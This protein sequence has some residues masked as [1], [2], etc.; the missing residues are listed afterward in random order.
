M[1]KNGR[2]MLKCKCVE[3]GITKTKF[4]KSQSGGALARYKGPSTTDKIAY[5]ASNFVTP[6]PSFGAMARLLAGQAFK[7]VKDNVDYYRKGK[8]I[9]IHK[10]ILKV[11]PK[12]GFVM[13][14]HKYTGPGNPLEKQVKWD[15]KTGK[16][17]EIYEKPTG[18]TDAVSMQHDVDYSVCANKP[19][20]KQVKC[21]NEADR[22]MVKSLDAI[23][24]KDRQ[25]GHAI[26]RNT[27]ATK[28]KVAGGH[29]DMA[30]GGDQ[31]GSIR[32]PAAACGI[33]GLK[34]TF[35]LV[36]YTGIMSIEFTLDHTGPM[37]RT[38]YDTAL[39]LEV[40]AG[41][42]GELDARQPRDLS[43]PESYTSKL[44]G[45]I[46]HLKLA[47]L[48]E[49]FGL[50]SSEAD[51]DELVRNAADRLVREAGATVEEVSVKM[52]LDGVKIYRGIG[53][54]GATRM[55]LDGAGFGTS[56]KMYYDTTLQEAFARGLKSHPND[57]SSTCKLSCLLGRYLLSEY[58]GTFYSKA[59][60]LGR[61]LCKA[62]DKVFED[63][64]VLL[65]PTIPKKAP[66]FPPANPSLEE[67]LG[68]ASSNNPNT[69]PFNVTGHPA[70]SIN[71]GFSDGLPVGMMI[72]GR[73]FDE[74][75]VLN[76]AYA[77]EKIRDALH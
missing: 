9:D 45:E 58:N 60:N 36:P 11:A 21:K 59:Q 62:Y 17:L 69:S 52:H 51:V 2:L 25:W 10:A 13:P 37:A 19:K 4:V 46:S 49:G 5:M 33:V 65:M 73:K 32:I 38:V 67:Y 57:L 48:K 68:K 14:G 34:P 66:T 40:L 50:P 6:A 77:Y 75:T 18:K 27:I 44:T 1:A 29:V 8:G 54:E 22:K 7:G 20:A 47:V 15:L 43:V 16:I 30:L 3:C 42:D 28:A 39:M 64:D 61:E 55:M 26:A 31:G 76:V 63:Y 53:V 41:L 74:A 70:L 72:V 23:P 71:A 56:A 24:W 35:G 12:K